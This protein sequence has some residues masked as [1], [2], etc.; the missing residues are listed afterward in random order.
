MFVPRASLD[1]GREVRWWRAPSPAE[2][3]RSWRTGRQ[4]WVM[5]RLHTVGAA[6]EPELVTAR[7][8]QEA[9]AG[10]Q[11]PELRAEA[12]SQPMAQPAAAGA[13]TEWEL[14]VKSGSGSGTVLGFVWQH[15]MERV[16]SRISK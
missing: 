10:R 5:G 7:R 1:P 13:R 4:C 9:Q 15:G 8:A 14:P 3:Q 11:C 6:W 2:C 16:F 12:R